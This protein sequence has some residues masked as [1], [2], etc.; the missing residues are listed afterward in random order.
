MQRIVLL[1]VVQGMTAL[2]CA[3]AGGDEETLAALLEADK[4]TLMGRV[5]ALWTSGTNSINALNA[6]SHLEANLVF[7]V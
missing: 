1:C 2:H 4:P 5:A 6:V 7:Q 3:A